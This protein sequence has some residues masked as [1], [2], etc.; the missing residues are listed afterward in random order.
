MAEPL[1]SALEDLSIGDGCPMRRDGLT[2]KRE[3]DHLRKCEE[4]ERHRHELET[5]DRTYRESTCGAAGVEPD[6][7]Q[8]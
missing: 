5:E 3:V 1:S 2:A 6:Q 4:P 8:Q 7:S